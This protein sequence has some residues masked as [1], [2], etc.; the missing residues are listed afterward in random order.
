ML[1]RVASIGLLMMAVALVAPAFALDHDTYFKQMGP[2]DLFEDSDS[3]LVKALPQ[4]LY[5]IIDVTNATFGG[6]G[7][8]VDNRTELFLG[9]G[10]AFGDHIFAEAAGYKYQALPNPSPGT[11][12]GWFVRFRWTDTSGQCSGYSLVRSYW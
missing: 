9:T 10:F 4:T 3:H 7:D 5:Q 6:D 8:R 11:Y 2:G 12:D 1:K